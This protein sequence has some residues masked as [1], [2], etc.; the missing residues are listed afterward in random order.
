MMKTRLMSGI[1]FTSLAAFIICVCI[2]TVL[3]AQSQCYILGGGSCV[4]NT[5]CAAC[6]PCSGSQVFGQPVDDYCNPGDEGSAPTCTPDPLGQATVYCSLTSTCSSS[7]T[8]CP[9]DSDL[10]TCESINPIKQYRPPNK[11]YGYCDSTD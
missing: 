8:V 2:D 7:L 3:E 1:L 5:S 11:L 10:Y 9:S 4:A 6:Q